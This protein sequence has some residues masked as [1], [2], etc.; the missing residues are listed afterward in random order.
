MRNIRFRA[1][2][3]KK[4]KMWSA[5]EMGQD[6]LTL[7]PDGRGFV[8]VSGTSTRLSRYL[9]HLIPMQFT[10]LHDKNDKEICEGDIVKAPAMFHNAICEVCWMMNCFCIKTI[11]KNGRTTSTGLTNYGGK[12]SP[13]II[14]NIHENRDLING[15]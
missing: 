13:E 6:Q 10:G 9:N 14:G 2:D 4:E 8:N 1:W 3:T 7:S 15:K 11:D 5:E 12:M